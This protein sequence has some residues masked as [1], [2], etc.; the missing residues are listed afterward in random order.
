V[1]ERCEKESSPL[2]PVH[3]WITSRAAETTMTSSLSSCST[4]AKIADQYQVPHHSLPGPSVAIR[5]FQI[6]GF[7]SSIRGGV[8]ALLEF[9]VD[10]RRYVTFILGV[11]PM[12][13]RGSPMSV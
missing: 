13:L 5:L 9:L 11:D 3:Q 1:S 6:Q 2:H 4:R 12:R 10:A 7:L 8:R